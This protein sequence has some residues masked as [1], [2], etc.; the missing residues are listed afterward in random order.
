M[1]V[2]AVW[3]AQWQYILSLSKFQQPLHFVSAVLAAAKSKF[4]PIFCSAAAAQCVQG[5]CAALF[6]KI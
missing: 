4:G 6:A 1:A 3:N 5:N 2:L